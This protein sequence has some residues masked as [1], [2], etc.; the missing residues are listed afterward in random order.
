MNKF[1][2]ITEVSIIAIVVIVI[3][4]VL[5]FNPITRL[6][7]SGGRAHESDLVIT[8]PN[9]KY[10][11]I[12]KEWGTIGGTGAEVY[13][14][15]NTNVNALTELFAVRI[16][17][18]WADDGCYPFRDGN[19]E[20]EWHENSVTIRYSSGARSETPAPSTWRTQTFELEDGKEKMIVTGVAL[21]IFVFMIAL[22]TVILVKRKNRKNKIT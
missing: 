7:A 17:D 18:T 9:G 21:F 8:S 2:K 22:M 20:M 6:I 11:I 5:I 10:T 12:I 13:S 3:L 14:L 19:Y 1:K 4:A 15:K 16:G